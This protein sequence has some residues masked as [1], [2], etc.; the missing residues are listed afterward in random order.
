M[1]VI[2][3][4]LWLWYGSWWEG[5]LVTVYNRCVY[6]CVCVSVNQDKLKLVFS[7]LNRYSGEVSVNT[8][9]LKDKLLFIFSTFIY[10]VVIETTIMCICTHPYRE[11]IKTLHTT[12]IKTVKLAESKKS[13]TYFML[14]PCIF[15]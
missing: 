14:I 11:T 10:C 5:K 7:S 13:T 6:V 1:R 15:L 12:V 8:P 3:P 9:L 4:W 2:Q